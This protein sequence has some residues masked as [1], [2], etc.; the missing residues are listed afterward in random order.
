MSFNS[1]DT[2]PVIH[3]G[4]YEEFF[5]LYMDQELNEEQIK[6]VDAFLLAHP[7]LQAEFEMLL[8]TKLPSEDCLISKE[9]L[10]ADSMKLSAVDDELLLYLDNELG[11]G[12]RSLVEAKISSDPSY[13]MQ[14]HL[15]SM[16]KLDASE[17]ISYPDKNELY[18]RTGKPAVFSLWA[19][20]AAAIILI[21][22]L[23][24][25]YFTGRPAAS[26][27]EPLTAGTP[28]PLPGRT[29]PQQRTTVPQ[30]GP[31]SPSLPGN[32]AP[33]PDHA[34]AKAVA[35][36]KKIKEAIR[37]QRQEEASPARSRDMADLS[38]R[39]SQE[40]GITR[41]EMPSPVVSNMAY[42]H[43]KEIINSSAVTSALSQRNTIKAPL[44]TVPKEDVASNNERKGSLKS[45]LRKATR[46]I[47]RKTG[48]DPA[49]G[50]DEELLI[51]AVALKLK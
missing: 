2:N 17:T 20:I 16:A 14:H 24:I 39:P 5:I 38:V 32:G 25:L 3:L 34:I 6:L 41:L 12:Q 49:N 22:A 43:P 48:I 9:S 26:G 30:P 29:A 8:S 45:F 21:A 37:R 42:I 40:K 15:L 4:N 19:R 47:E 50:E 33:N 46:V 28:K 10:F 44:P 7:D 31:L 13:R 51:G 23:G 1:N 11:A 35:P 27:P 18:R 36:K